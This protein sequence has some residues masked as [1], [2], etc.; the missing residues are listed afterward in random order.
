L[1]WY[2]W[3]KLG[4]SWSIGYSKDRGYY[5]ECWR[6]LDEPVKVDGRWYYRECLIEFAR[7]TIIAEAKL[8][9][10]LET[11]YKKDK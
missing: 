7:H 8:Q 5:A 4:W 10:R 2:K 6:D 1:N 3:E 9:E 11:R